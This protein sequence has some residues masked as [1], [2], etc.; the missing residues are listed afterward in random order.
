MQDGSYYY[1]LIYLTEMPMFCFYNLDV[2]LSMDAMMLLS[3][4]TFQYIL[5]KSSLLG[6]YLSKVA[7]E[8]SLLI[9]PIKCWASALRI[10]MWLK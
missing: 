7:N 6:P 10:K 5:V 1:F 9:L 2:F 8:N 4:D 3:L